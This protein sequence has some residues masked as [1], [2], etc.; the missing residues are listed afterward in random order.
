MQKKHRGL[1]SPTIL[2]IVLVFFHESLKT[3]YFDE[4]IHD[5]SGNLVIFLIWAL[6]TYLLVLYTR[7]LFWQTY[8]PNKTGK[9][10][11]KVLIELSSIVTW[12]VSISIA[13]TMLLGKDL[14]AILAASS[15]TIGI[16]GFA[17]RSMIA[18]FFYGIAIAMEQP[19]RVGDWI[20]VEGKVGQVKQI[21]WSFTMIVTKEN[22]HLTLPNSLILTNSFNNYSH[23]DPLWRSS[24]RM[25]L[26]YDVTTEEAERLFLSSINQVAEC[27]HSSKSPEVRII[28][29]LSNGIEWEIRF[30]IKDYPLESKIKYQ[31]QCNILRDLSYCNISLPAKKLE[32]FTEKLS[33]H[34][35]Y[36]N[37]LGYKREQRDNW[38][39]NLDL[40][41]VL[42]DEECEKISAQ[43]TKQ[44][45]VK[46]K[47]LFKQG[48]KGSS[49]FL[50]YQGLLDVVIKGENEQLKSVGQLK[51]GEVLGEN[52][53]LTGE[54]RSATII[55]IVN[56]IIYEID[57][58]MIEPYFHRYPALLEHIEQLLTER[59]LHNM[60]LMLEQ[61]EQSVEEIK[62][63]V[64]LEV[65]Q[66]IR[67]FFNINI[68]LPLKARQ[69]SQFHEDDNK[70]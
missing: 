6:G 40:F 10:T 12:I 26:G 54:P 53:L 38:A 60:Q 23:P 14:G 68:N 31:I 55:P 11:P 25:V 69:D 8:A 19:Y 63:N 37:N 1:I 29:F 21:S 44:L 43:A 3:T 32:V 65:K 57:K 7:I 49:L 47:P 18:D 20:N 5:L 22:I 52:S 59:K 56:S 4:A 46:G 50:V 33:N 30:W 24:F 17:L 48:D 41:K 42:N 13:M 27:S 15:V 51:V 45:I 36:S 2:F 58:K 28:K 66:K 64:M 62:A 35:Q 67:G 34:A 16:L 39:R 61:D 70:S 9:T